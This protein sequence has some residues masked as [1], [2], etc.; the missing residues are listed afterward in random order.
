MPA[1]LTDTH[2]H[3]DFPELAADLDGVLLRASETGVQRI[4]SIGTS[5]EG[6]RRAVALAEQHPNV[7]A[8]VGLH[9]S[10]VDEQSAAALPELR[11]LAEHPRVVAIG[12]IGLDYHWLPTATA[13][14]EQKLSE[15]NAPTLSARDEELK[16]FQAQL[17]AAQLELAQNAGLNVVIHQRAAWEETLALLRQHAGGCTAVYHCFT[18]P[19]ARA[20]AVLALG[21][22]VSFTGIVTFKNAAEAQRTVAGVPEERYMVETDA[23]Y[24][25]PVPHRGKPCE[26]AYT[27]LVAEHVARLRGQSLA[28]VAERTEQTANAF[29]F[30]KA[31]ARGGA[32]RSAQLSAAR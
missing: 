26:P 3:L 9:P 12:E 14:R 1:V 6:S 7:W 16:A 11:R 20:E 5:L 32:V 27:R 4:V 31:A 18:E 28:E 30:E 25:A 22:L 8:T 2:A 24:L 17:F 21:H 29:F 15:E 23:P 10:S 13:Q 19:L